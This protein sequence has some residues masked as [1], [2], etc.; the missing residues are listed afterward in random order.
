MKVRLRSRVLYGIAEELQFGRQP[1]RQE[2]GGYLAGRFDGKSLEVVS[3]W[4]DLNA[5]RTPGSIRLRESHLDYVTDQITKSGDPSLYVVGTWHVHPP[6]YGARPSPTDTEYLFLEH[7]AIRAGGLADSRLPQAHLIL[8]WG[9]VYNY[10]VYAMRADVAGLKLTPCEQQ[11]GHL[12]AIEAALQQGSQTGILLQSGEPPVETYAGPL[13]SEAFVAGD[14]DGLFWFFPYSAIDEEVE[15]VYLANF[16]HHVRQGARSLHRPNRRER[17]ALTYYRIT[18]ADGRYAVTAQILEFPLDGRPPEA[19]HVP[20]QISEEITVLLHNPDAPQEAVLNLGAQA[21]TQVGDIGRMMQSFLGLDAPPLLST[22]RPL[23]EEKKWRERTVM[24]EFGYVL[25][26]DDVNVGDLLDDKTAGAVTLYWR[27]PG[28]HPR[29]IYDLRTQRLRGLGYD[30]QLLAGSSV[31]VAGLGLLG[32]ELVLLL[33]AVGLGKLSLVDEGTVDFTNIYRQRLYES[34]DVYQPKVEVAVR[35]LAGSGMEV[36]GHRLSIPMVS[37][38]PNRFQDA[39]AR[40]DGLVA[41]SKLVIGTV[42]SF[43]AR[44][45]LQALC[46]HHRVPFLSVALDWLDPVGAQAGIF[47]AM[48]DRPGCYAC[49]RGL[50]PAWDRGVCTVAPLEFSPIASGFAFRLAMNILHGR[51]AASRAIQ[52]Y[53]DL[54]VEEHD[55]A[56]ADPQCAVCGPDGV[57]RKDKESLFKNL[58]RWL[59]GEA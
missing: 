34:G 12:Q 47:L 38:N 8:N 37:G 39:L 41:Q 26:P 54:S 36:E 51:V 5:A 35:R 19:S 27:S 40:L 59:I 20:C 31:L 49:G 29:I 1:F 4:R 45:V 44:A 21:H 43:S 32:S 56:G 17:A 2:E 18:V 50:V 52:I 15:Q 11:P 14:L 7:A 13:I 28:L 10:R 16:V 6:G 48:P 33:I 57:G 46:L 23:E 24:D 9:D 30:C 58:S 55:L 22:R 53:P 42:D 25:L 3:Y